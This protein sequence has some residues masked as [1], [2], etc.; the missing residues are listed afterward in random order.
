MSTHVGADRVVLGWAE[1]GTSS[2]DNMEGLD[3]SEPTGESVQYLAGDQWRL[4][5]TYNAVDAQRVFRSGQALGRRF[6]R[7]FPYR[8]PR[9]MGS[10]SRSRP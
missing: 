7:G 5:G 2:V 6:A 8:L 10:L 3:A 1:G 4:L 9:R